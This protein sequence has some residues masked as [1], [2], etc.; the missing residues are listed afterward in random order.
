MAIGHAVI[1]DFD[2]LRDG[3]EFRR[4]VEA[5]GGLWADFSD[6]Y[7]AFLDEVEASDRPADRVAA[8]DVAIQELTG[9]IRSDRPY[10][11]RL[12]ALRYPLKS[13]KEKATV[14]SELKRRGRDGLSSGGKAIFD[15]VEDSS[16][17]IG[18]F[19]VPCGERES[20]LPGI[21]EYSGNKP[22]WTEEA[23]VALAAGKLEDDHPLRTFMLRV[24]EFVL[25]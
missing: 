5:L 6:D 12:D 7:K 9:I 15:V 25:A 4:L 8:A 20:W 10:R 11:E 19:I 3:N 14:W 23:L 22:A 17:K 21:V 24:R 1:V 13:V 2:I 18:L 16:A